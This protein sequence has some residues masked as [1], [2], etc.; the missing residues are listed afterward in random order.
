[1]TLSKTLR[2]GEWVTRARI[3]NYSI[4]MLGISVII[5]GYLA[6]TSHGMHDYSGR[7][8]GTDFSNVYAAGTYA[9]DGVP[10][11]PF[12]PDLQFAREKELFGPVSDFYSWNYPPYFLL[13]AL[14]LA[15]MPY[16]SAL[17]F[18]QLATFGA[19]LLAMRRILPLKEAW[20]PAI[21]FGAVIINF[22]HGNNGFLTAA[23]FAGGLVALPKRPLLAGM[24]LACLA[25]K[26]Q[27]G[28]FIPFALAA[29]GYW[30]AFFSAT[31]TLLLLTF[32]SVYA[33]GMNSWQAWLDSAAFTQHILLEQGDTG[34]FKM[35]SMFAWVRALG[36]SIDAAY[37]VQGAMVL[38]VFAAVLAIWRS[39][40]EYALKA[41][42]LIIGTLLAVPYSFDY[43]LMLLAVALVFYVQHGLRNGFAPY[44]K[45]ILMVSW[46]VPF[47]ARPLAQ[48]TGIFLGPVCLIA[49]FSLLLREYRGCG[50]L[51]A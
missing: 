17:L 11:A 15:A 51:P 21:G 4:L 26:P 30:R 48:H 5:I 13:L 8:L 46:W 32:M 38:L 31:L 3:R 49:L 44:V 16:I 45:T 37:D 43:D 41:V 27:Y 10:Q 50:K 18:Y 25:Y 2:S 28:I 24:L 35:Q 9:R 7:I 12:N 42:A 1:M 19:Y 22:G 34:F 23:L 33:F 20:L 39:K 6:A 40:M 14:P 29:G 47:F 36:G